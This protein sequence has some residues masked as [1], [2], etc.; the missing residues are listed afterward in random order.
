MVVPIWFELA[1][2]NEGRASPRF[3]L[4]AIGRVQS[5]LTLIVLLQWHECTRIGATHLASRKTTKTCARSRIRCTRL[6]HG[7]RATPPGEAN[8]K[9]SAQDAHSSNSGDNGANDDTHV[10]RAAAT[11]AIARGA[12]W[13]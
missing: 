2:V 11:A 8:A 10:G 1:A 6:G 9:D 4:I 3:K 13:R 12:T 5:S 7:G